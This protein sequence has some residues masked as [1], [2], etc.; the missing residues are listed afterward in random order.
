MRNT[1]M[2]HDNKQ[3]GWKGGIFE[4]DWKTSKEIEDKESYEIVTR[5]NQKIKSNCVE[6]L[7]SKS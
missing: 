5:R 2:D 6:E 7:Q 1:I 4:T 3:E